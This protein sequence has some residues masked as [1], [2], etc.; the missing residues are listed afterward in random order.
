MPARI[1]LFVFLPGWLTFYLTVF[2]VSEV[3][4]AE[5]GS[6][7][8]GVWLTSLVWGTAMAATVALVCWLLFVRPNRGQDS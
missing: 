5:D 2:F 1:R 3:L 7:D 8:G 4:D 6:K